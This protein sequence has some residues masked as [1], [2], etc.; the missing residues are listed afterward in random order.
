MANF[1]LSPGGAL[2]FQSNP[3]PLSGAADQFTENLMRTLQLQAESQRRAQQAQAEGRQSLAGGIIGG[4]S[5]LAQGG[6]KLGQD[7]SQGGMLRQQLAS[8][9]G[10]ADPS[11]LGRR[12][13]FTPDRVTARE[14]ALAKATQPSFPAITESFNPTG[15]GSPS[16]LGRQGKPALS[17]NRTINTAQEKD[18]LLDFFSGF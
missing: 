10:V 13:Q 1:Q 17:L 14:D 15:F 8:E 9:Q 12:L 6:I 7:L 18:R 3:V 4:L 2:S 16:L 5:G 11:E